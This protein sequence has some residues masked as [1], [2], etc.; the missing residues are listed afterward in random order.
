MSSG[1][2]TDLGA[3]LREL[4]LPAVTLASIMASYIVRVTRSAML[5]VL[6]EDYMRTAVAKGL[7]PLAVIWRHGVRNALLAVVT[8]TGLYLGNLIGNSVLTR[9]RLQ[10]TGSRQADCGSSCAA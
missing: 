3:H 4:V 6:R 8:I 1:D 7:P 9:N 5:E 10:S 2:T